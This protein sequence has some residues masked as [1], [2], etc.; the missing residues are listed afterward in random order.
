MKTVNLNEKLEYTFS[1]WITEQR[2]YRYFY[3]EKDKFSY[4]N[5]LK[6]LNLKVNNLQNFINFFTNLLKKH[7]HNI[8]IEERDV[9]WLFNFFNSI[10]L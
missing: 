1:L 7:N 8:F 9:F 2:E 6:N 4:L 5:F 3:S 10:Y